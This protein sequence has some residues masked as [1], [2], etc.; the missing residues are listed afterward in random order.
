MFDSTS[1]IIRNIPACRCIEVE[2]S[3]KLD[4]GSV[5]GR[6][7]VRQGNTSDRKRARLP[8]IVTGTTE[9]DCA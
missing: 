2:S 6:R 7:V 8:R 5:A 3:R 1:F 4:V 9:C